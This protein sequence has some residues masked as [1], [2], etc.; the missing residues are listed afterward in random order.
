MSSI[1]TSGSSVADFGLGAG[2]AQSCLGLGLAWLGK[3]EPLV[4]DCI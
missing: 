3:I 1:L 2:L 4:I